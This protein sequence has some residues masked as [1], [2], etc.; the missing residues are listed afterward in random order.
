[1]TPDQITQLRLH[2]LQITAHQFSSPGELLQHMGAMQAQEYANALWAIAVRLPGFT[3]QQVEQAIEDR[4]I[5][6]TWP[7]RGTIHFVPAEDAKWMVQLMAPKVLSSS[8]ARRRQLNLTNEFVDEYQKVVVN[9]LKGGVIM[10]RKELVELLSGRG[11]ETGGQRGIHILWELAARGV[12]C[13][14][15][16]RGKQPTFVLLDE[17]V[18]HSKQLTHDEACLQMVRWYFTSHGP[19]TIKDFTAWTRLTVRETKTALTQL[20]N[21]LE[22]TSVDGAEYWFAKS[23]HMP[24]RQ[25]PDVQLLPAFDEYMIGYRDRSAMLEAAHASKVVPGGN[26]VFLPIIVVNG[27]IRGTWKRTQTAKK[28][29]I[30]LLPFT[31]LSSAELA[32]ATQIAKRYGTFVGLPVE[33][34]L[35]IQ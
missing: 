11:I 34:G 13:F 6:R 32:S 29:T 18:P 31:K 15:P 17:W 21:L 12:L 10:T 28:A 26:G 7:M 25:S 22:S 8:A 3:R 1:M 14:G 20:D 35:G 4:Q 30:T 9:A 23:A 19:A 5:V 33:V 24:Q 27:Q 2:N 16:Y